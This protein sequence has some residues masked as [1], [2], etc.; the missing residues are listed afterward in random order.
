MLL[1]APQL[2]I[3]T[4]GFSPGTQVTQVWQ[5]GLQLLV[6]VLHFYLYSICTQLYS[7]VFTC[8]LDSGDGGRVVVQSLFQTVVLLRVEDVDQPISAGRRQQ[9]QAWNRV[10]V[11]D[12]VTDWLRWRGMNSLWAW[13]M[14]RS[15]SK[16]ILS[17]IFFASNCQQNKQSRKRSVAPFIIRT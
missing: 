6:L 7:N 10:T 1:S 13:L 8:E 14:N 16:C 15:D 11:T 2:T 3:L 4:S 9:L 12:V 5:L 17:F